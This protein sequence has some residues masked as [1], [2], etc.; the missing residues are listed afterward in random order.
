M[1]REL[2]KMEHKTNHKANM[3]SKCLRAISSRCLAPRLSLFLCSICFALCSIASEGNA[4]SVFVLKIPDGQYSSV[5]QNQSIAS[6]SDEQ[7]VVQDAAGGVTTYTRLRRYDTPDGQFIAYASREAQRVIQWPV[8]NRGAMRIGT[9]QNGRIEFSQ[10]RMSVFSA[11]S[12]VGQGLGNRSPNEQPMVFDE[13]QVS[14]PAGYPSMLL[15]TGEPNSRSF[16]RANWSQ[17]GAVASGGGVQFVSQAN[18]PQAA[19]MITPVGGDMVRVQQA[20][21]NQWAALGVDPR[22]IQGFGNGVLAQRGARAQIRFSAVNNSVSQLWRIEQQFGGGYCFESV[23][24]PG[25]GMTCI[26]NQGLWLQPLVY[27]PWQIWWAQQPSFT[28]SMPQYR[29]ANE[30]IVPN[31]PLGPIS[32]RV[33][34][35]HS[36]AIVVLLADRR[37]PNAPRKLRI[38]AGGSEVLVLERDSGA[39]INQ[40]TEFVDGFGNWD[41]RE[42]QIPVPPVVLYDV[43]VYE[44]F[45]QSIAI[46][47]TGKSPNVIEDI[48]Y[49]PRSVGFLLLPPGD[50]LQDNSVLDVYRAAADSKNPGAVRKLSP[51]DYNNSSSSKPSSAV[52][53]SDPLND[54]LKQLQGKRGAF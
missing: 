33:A 46:D 17:G 39:T 29:I 16:L 12:D 14:S 6:I 45:L 32:L 35:T 30:Q 2:L 13:G 25:L 7:L 9:L 19:W 49:Q 38:P 15:A 24:M 53:S 21:G 20:V 11:D 44:E 5:S 37:N 8:A 36:E 50:Q 40:T 52:P 34:N 42:Y 3:I 23:A 28:V 1:L 54:L 10:S 26:P 43:S 22:D 4:Q 41:R 47:R 18:D 31:P 48:N 27:S 51:S